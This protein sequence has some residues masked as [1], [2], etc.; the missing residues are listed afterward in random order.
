[1]IGQKDI[2]ADMHIHTIGSLHA[3]STLK[4]CIECAETNGMK[5]IAI[6]DHYYNDGTTFR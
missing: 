2:I 4:E 3:Y 5:Y 6:T 1:M